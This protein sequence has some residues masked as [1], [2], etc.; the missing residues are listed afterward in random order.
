MQN[1]SFTK[2][3]QFVIYAVFSHFNIVLP[4]LLHAIPPAV[5]QEQM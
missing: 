2:F 1:M 4:H 5:E 3:S